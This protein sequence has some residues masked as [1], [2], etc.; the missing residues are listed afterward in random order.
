MTMFDWVVIATVGTSALLALFRGFIREVLSLMAWLIAAFVTVNNFKPLMA[1]LTPHIHSKAVLMGVSSVGLFI[2]VLIVMSI[3]NAL[4][5]RFL[6]AGGDISILDSML[7]MV[8]GVFRGLFILSLAFMMLKMVMTPEEYPDAIKEAR[9]LSFVEFG[10]RMLANVAPNYVKE[11]GELPKN[12]QAM[13]EK[14]PKIQGD[15]LEMLQK[16][17]V[18]KVKNAPDK[19]P[20]YDAKNRVDLDRLLNALER[21]EPTVDAE[22][23][24]HAIP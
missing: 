12:A 11:V 7:G 1:K 5:L 21:E 10:A 16:Q 3:L 6:K 9:T 19:P 22:P 23:K 2:A 20:S 8:F 18:P 13:R 14:M 24:G 17:I 15:Q 4:I